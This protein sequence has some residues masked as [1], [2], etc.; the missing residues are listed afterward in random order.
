MCS[1]SA[2]R[3]CEIAGERDKNAGYVDKLD[4]N[5]LISFYF[6]EVG[7]VFCKTPLSEMAHARV[8]FQSAFRAVGFALISNWDHWKCR[9]NYICHFSAP[10][11]S[12]L[13]IIKIHSQPSLATLQPLKPASLL[14]T[15]NRLHFL[16]K[17]RFQVQLGTGS[18]CWFHSI[19]S[20]K[21]CHNPWKS[22]SENKLFA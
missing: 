8:E 20:R 4:N 10:A 2:A 22:N 1:L 11:V 14:Q 16:G 15:K 5:R 13:V 9:D 7:F 18:S 12:H 19:H 3:R 6:I 21:V 17:V